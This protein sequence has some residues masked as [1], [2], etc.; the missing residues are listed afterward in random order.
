[1]QRLAVLAAHTR[2]AGSPVRS[3][4]DRVRSR[5][6]MH[7]SVSA[8]PGA[9]GAALDDFESPQFDTESLVGGVAVSAS[10]LQAMQTGDYVLHARRGQLEQIPADKTVRPCQ[11]R[12]LLGVTPVQHHVHVLTQPQLC[13]T[14]MLAARRQSVAPSTRTRRLVTPKALPLDPVG[15]T[16]RLEL[17]VAPDGIVY[18]AQCSILSRSADSGRSWA[19]LCRAVP[20]GKPNEP[21]PL[22]DNHFLNFRVLPSGTWIRARADN[23]N[24]A[25]RDTASAPLSPSEVSIS[26]STTEGDTWQEISRIGSEIAAGSSLDATVRLGS[27]E[28]D[29]HGGVLVIVGMVFS[30]AGSR[31][32]SG[33]EGDVVDM[34]TYL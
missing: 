16:Q 15:H 19:H 26:V 6:V 34:K 7:V 20:P 18:A 9:G 29:G 30:T 24:G 27:L 12:P 33:G 28:V 3:S 22:P 31:A 25:P 23:E 8:A 21:A 11:P 17:F 13:V 4:N 10:Q 1:M 32:A 2:S 5:A 14:L